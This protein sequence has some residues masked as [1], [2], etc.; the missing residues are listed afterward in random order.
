MEKAKML[1]WDEK[2]QKARSHK[3]IRRTGA[4]KQYHY[5]YNEPE[6]KTFRMERPFD[7]TVL[8][9][10]RKAVMLG[11]AAVMATVFG[12]SPL[13][14]QTKFGGSYW[15]LESSQVTG[16]GT[17]AKPFT[18][19]QSEKGKAPQGVMSREAFRK[20]VHKGM[21][22]Q[23]V[24]QA[25]GKPDSTSGTGRSLHFEYPHKT[26]DT[27]TGKV[28]YMTSVSFWDGVVDSVGFI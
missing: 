13:M 27:I 8:P 20:V 11:L 1:S 7:V 2:I 15:N 5:V 28:D 21:T 6:G 24:I 26:M 17:K 12:V 4:P 23:Q 3:Y 18:I 10:S 9:M 22:L 25:V 16:E 14:A 19:Q